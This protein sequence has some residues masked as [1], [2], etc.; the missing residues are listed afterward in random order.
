MDSACPNLTQWSIVLYNL[1]WSF[2]VDPK[3]NLVHCEN[4][5]SI[6]YFEIIF[7]L[8]RY[9]IFKCPTRCVQQPICIYMLSNG[10]ENLGENKE[11]KSCLGDLYTPINKQFMII[12]FLRIYSL[13]NEF[14]ENVNC[15]ILLMSFV[16][17]RCLYYGMFGTHF[18]PETKVYCVS[19]SCTYQFYTTMEVH[20]FHNIAYI[21]SH[22]LKIPLSV[23]LTEPMIL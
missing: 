4:F 18:V 1:W 14:I 10:I 17:Y 22:C 9:Y 8:R 11:N 23:F 13:I 3:E 6:Y 5:F 7:I 15:T 16:I 20:N 12:Y 2:L 21:F 19:W